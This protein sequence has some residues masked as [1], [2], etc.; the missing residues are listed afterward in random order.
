MGA[1]VEGKIIQ[2]PTAMER[3]LEKLYKC[4]AKLTAK[5]EEQFDNETYRKLNLVNYHIEVAK[6]RNKGK[7]YNEQRT[8]G[9]VAIKPIDVK[10]VNY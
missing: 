8:F 5:L 6:Q 7:W 1:K 9:T 4:Q 2:E 10:H 3:K